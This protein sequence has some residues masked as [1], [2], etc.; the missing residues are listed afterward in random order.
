MHATGP[1]VLAQA[2]LLELF[3]V[4][5][6]SVKVSQALYVEA[7][8]GTIAGGGEANNKDHT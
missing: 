4:L 2:P 8:F 6:F 1:A 3:L 7:F 5:P